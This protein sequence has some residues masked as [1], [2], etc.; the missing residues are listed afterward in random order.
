MLTIIP[1]SPAFGATEKTSHRK[2]AFLCVPGMFG[3][4]EVEVLYPS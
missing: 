3:S 4:L 2:M 1:E